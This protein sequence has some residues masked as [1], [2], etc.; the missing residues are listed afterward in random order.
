MVNGE[1][2]DPAPGQQ[3]NY[4]IY[5]DGRQ[6]ATQRFE[7]MGITHQDLRGA[8]DPDTQSYMLPLTRE[9]AERIAKMGNVLAVERMAMDS[10]QNV[11]PNDTAYHWTPDDF[12]PLWVPKKG[13]TVELDAQNIPLYRDIIGKYEGNKLEERDGRIFINDSETTSY[14]FKMDYYFMMGDNRHNS[15]DSRFWGFVPEDHVV[16]KA[17][18]IWLSIDR[19]KGLPSGIRWRRMM[20][21]VK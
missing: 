15:L 8:Y 10:S 13:E 14:T 4:F 7:E 9:N 19:E 17:L 3:F 18:F 21:K 11:F 20:R 16:G 6:I 1:V 2:F 12:G 5:T